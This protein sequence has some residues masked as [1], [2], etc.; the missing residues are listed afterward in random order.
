[1]PKTKLQWALEAA[2]KGMSVFPL[3]GTKD[4]G[5]CECG[6]TDEKHGHGKHPLETLTPRGVLDASS[7]PEQIEAWWKAAP[8]ANIGVHPGEDFVVVDLDVKKGNNGISAL[9]EH[10]GVDF[11]ELE[12]ETFT[13]NTP[14]GGKHLYY[15][16]EKAFGNSVGILAGV[17][18]RGLN[19]YVIAPGSQIGNNSY[20]VE[21]AQPIAPLREDIEKLLK[22]PRERQEK[23]EKPMFELD[24]PASIS[25]AKEFLE[26]REPA[27]EGNGGDEHTFVTMCHLKDIGVSKEKSLDILT[28]PGGWNERCDPPW[29]AAELEV[30]LGNVYRYGKDRPGSK[31]GGVMEMYE[32]DFG[33]EVQDVGDV[34]AQIVKDNHEKKSDKFAALEAIAFSGMGIV[35]RGKRREYLIPG[36]LPAHGFTALLAKRSVGKTVTMMDMALRFSC[37]MPWHGLP[38]RSGITAVYLC[39][40][41]D[42]G[43]GE[44]VRAWCKSTGQEPSNDRFILMAGITDLMS[45][46]DVQLWAEFLHQKVGDKPTVVFVDT[47]QRAAAKGGQNSDE[48]MQK[49]VHHVEQLAEVLHGPVI[50]AFHPPK[51][52]DR[53]VMGSSVIENS[54]TAI[55]NL[56]EQASNRRLEVTRIKGPGHGNYNLF[57]FDVIGLG[58]RDEYDNEITGVVP[59]KVGGQEQTMPEE[60][61]NTEK[62]V[63]AHIIVTL[64]LERKQKD[65]DS[66]PYSVSA[67]SKEIEE[68]VKASSDLNKA[69]ELTQDAVWAKALVDMM[70]KIGIT[71]F[72]NTQ[73]DLKLKDLFR[74]DPRGFELPDNQ[75]LRLTSDGKKIRRFLIERAGI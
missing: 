2:S 16:A 55:W 37:D 59:T 43:A 47:W 73:I 18:S 9:E 28:L 15:E 57:K 44:Q 42:E 45:A 72:S 7:I 35:K 67:M 21:S 6:N 40:E 36:W 66:K 41:D 24:M 49:A 50:A 31:G 48:E 1:M 60:Q 10:L 14:T 34:L 39:G 23:A 11:W 56:T 54:T 33:I 8:N 51:H 17:D 46:E 68:L 58:E 63:F 61:L 62:E 20:S 38:A 13:V 27:V 26:H 74:H 25:R 30:K 19:G 75:I 3:Y 4:D 53:V 22:A 64:D 69:G 5:L 52:D 70:R 12:A 65:P 32:G 29:D 71:S